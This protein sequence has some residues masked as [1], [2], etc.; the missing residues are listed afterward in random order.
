[1]V[2]ANHSSN[3]QFDM[4]KYEKVLITKLL[5]ICMQRMLQDKAYAIDKEIDN[6]MMI[7]SD[8][9][10]TITNHGICLTNNAAH[11]N[12]TFKPSDFLKTFEKTF[13]PAKSQHE[14]KNID[15]DLAAHHLT[16]L[17]DGNSYKDLKRGTDWAASSNTIFNLGIHSSKDVADIRGW[18]DRIIKIPSGYITKISIKQLEIE[19]DYTLRSLDMKHRGCRFTEETDDLS[20]IKS[21]SKVNCFFDC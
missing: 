3:Y 6:T 9:L 8:F 5:P 1:M 11:V 2:Q 21:Y 15:T 14:V 12:K 20:S 10:P 13:Y 18:L 4:E 7:C 16:F 19:A 17:I